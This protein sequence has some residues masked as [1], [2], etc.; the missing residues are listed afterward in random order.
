MKNSKQRADMHIVSDLYSDFP[1]NSLADGDRA[2]STITKSR[3]F[4]L[5]KEFDPKH[6]Q[7]PNFGGTSLKFN[8]V[9]ISA[10]HKPSHGLLR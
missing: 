10:Y 4:S 5:G 1:A 8:S 6:S 7:E 2:A 9:R 3:D